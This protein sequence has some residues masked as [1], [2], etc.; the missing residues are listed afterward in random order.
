MIKLARSR[1]QRSLHFIIFSFYH[2]YE[3][4]GLRRRRLRLTLSF[5]S[6]IDGKCLT[7]LRT[8]GA[9]AL[10]LAVTSGTAK[11]VPFH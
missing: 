10:S 7:V 2:Q 9:K 4:A 11:A 3:S 8:S 5:G 6:K 1:N